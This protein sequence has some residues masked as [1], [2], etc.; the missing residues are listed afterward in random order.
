MAEFYVSVPKSSM[1]LQIA[2]LINS[3]NNLRKNHTAHTILGSNVSYFVEVINDKVIGCVGLV[4][5]YPTLSE[6]KHVSVATSHRKSG[7]A[8]KLINLAIAN[9]KTE[10]VYMSIRSD[11]IPSLKMAESMG[12]VF[13]RRDHKTNYDIVTVGRKKDHGKTAG[14]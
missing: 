8:T 14:W 13:V 1:A 3:Y 11:N 12:F 9:S 4:Q 7:I 2:A 10:F 6:I 5:K